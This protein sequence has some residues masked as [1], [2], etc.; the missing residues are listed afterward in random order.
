MHIAI[1]GNGVA[2]ITAARYIRKRSDHDITVISDETEYFFSRT[3]LMYVFMG[4]ERFED[5]KPYEDFFW[6]K[7]RINLMRAY[8]QEID[9]A[10]KT[11][12]CATGQV[13]HYD[14][15]IVA[16]GSKSNKFGWPGQDLRGVQG[17]YHWQDVELLEDNVRH[18]NNAVIVGGGLIGIELAEMLLSRKIPVTFLVR[19]SSYWNN[20]LPPE[21]SAMINR[22][23]YEH[24]VDLRLNTTLREI[25][26]DTHGQVR[27]VVTGTGEEIS[28]EVVGLTPGV[29]PNIDVVKNTPIETDRGILVDDHL[30]TNVADVYAIG[31]C[32]QLRKPPPGRKPLEPVWYTGKLMG[33]TV[34]RTL[35]KTPTPYRPGIWYNSA[36]FFDIEYQTYGEV[37]PDIGS[38]ATFIWQDAARR[39][40]LRFAMHTETF[41]VTGINALGIRLR[42]NLADRMIR[43]QWTLDKA[44]AHLKALIFDPEF[45]TNIAPAIVQVYNQQFPT[46]KVR[47]HRKKQWYSLIFPTTKS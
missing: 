25:L 36:K 24:H 1:I 23:I 41:A 32:A 40:L 7:N 19:E 31:D 16:T 38:E 27:G 21:E 14:K 15:L 35:C 5:I 33:K 20:V 10:Q 43:E 4:H 39:Q 18:A 46:R 42:H 3:A 29:H 37:P 44:M 45:Y 47:L 28:C 12:Q 34:A 13:I 2:G 11:L 9:T 26:A 8:V 30:Q 22:H 17:L 6:A